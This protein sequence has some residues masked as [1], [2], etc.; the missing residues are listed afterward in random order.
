M[1]EPIRQSV[2]TAIK[3]VADK[4]GIAVVIDKMAVV[5]GGQEITAD[6]IAELGKK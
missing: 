3:K 2:D 6:V 1:V 5:Y 4:K